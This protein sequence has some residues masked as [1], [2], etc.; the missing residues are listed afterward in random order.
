MFTPPSKNFFANDLVQRIDIRE[1]DVGS[2]W[3]SHRENFYLDGF[4]INKIGNLGKRKPPNDCKISSLYSPKVT[5]YATIFLKEII[6]PFSL[7]HTITTAWHFDIVH[8]TRSYK[9]PCRIHMVHRGL[10]KIASD[11]INCRNT[12]FPQEHSDIFFIALDYLN[13]TGIAMLSPPQI[14]RIQILVLYFH[15]GHV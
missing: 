7:C 4:R 12:W 6:G 1:I 10:C 13:L 15:G 9:M 3:F 11:S 2:I 5:V 14:H 8:G